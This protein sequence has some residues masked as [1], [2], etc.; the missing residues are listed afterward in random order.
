MCHP[1]VFAAA[2]MVLSIAGTYMSMK[3]A[4]DQRGRAQKAA[5]KEEVYAEKAEEIQLETLDAQIEEVED[6]GE[7]EILDRQRQ[8]LRERAKIRVAASESGAFGNSTLRQLSASFINEGYDTGIIDY[9][10][11]SATAQ[12]G[13]QKRALRLNT[14]RQINNAYAAVPGSTPSWMQGLNILTS[15]ASGGLE[16]YQMGQTILA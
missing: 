9:N 3:K 10:T 2:T 8:A 4:D 14:D 15:G 5:E 6:K 13:R 16:G 11:R 12:A 7:L 1:M